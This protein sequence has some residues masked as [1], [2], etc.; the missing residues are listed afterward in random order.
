MISSATK[1]TKS[2]L[3]ALKFI[4]S[5]LKELRIDD[6]G[7]NFPRQVLGFHYSTVKTT[8]LRNPQLVGISEDACKLLDVDPD[9]AAQE[10]DIL[11]GSKTP[12]SSKAR[13]FLTSAHSSLLRRTSVRKPGWTAR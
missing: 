5:A 7:L 6:S 13:F 11:I 9:V 12:S 2:S 8:P 10:L 3:E 1:T 4:N